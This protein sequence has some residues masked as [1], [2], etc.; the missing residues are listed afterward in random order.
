MGRVGFLRVHPLSLLR[1]TPCMPAWRISLATLFFEQRMPDPMTSSAW[2][3]GA[4]Y[5]PRLDRW[6]SMIRLVISASRRALDDIG[7]FRQS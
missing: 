4:P 5:V 2:I 6:I 7:L 1:W 3:L